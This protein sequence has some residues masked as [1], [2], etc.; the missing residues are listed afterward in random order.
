MQIIQTTLYKTALTPSTVLPFALVYFLPTVLISPLRQF[1]CL[2]S[3]SPATVPD[4]RAE[5]M[6]SQCQESLAQSWLL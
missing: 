6:H 1:I 4:W 3:V 5:A 2:P